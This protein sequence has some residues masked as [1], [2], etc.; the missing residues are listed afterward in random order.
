VILLSVTYWIVDVSY[1]GPS[2]L[3]RRMY[4]TSH[5]HESLYTKGQCLLCLFAVLSGMALHLAP[6]ASQQAAWPWVRSWVTPWLR[7]VDTQDGSKHKAERA[8]WG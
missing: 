3:P 5:D 7:V 1:S 2:Y 8:G 6:W 4:A